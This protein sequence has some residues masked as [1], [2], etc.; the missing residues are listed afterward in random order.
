VLVGSGIISEA[1]SPPKEIVS[2]DASPIVMLPPN[3]KLPSI[4]ALPVISKKDPEIPPKF[5]S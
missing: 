5:T 4:L 3:T 1:I 2:E